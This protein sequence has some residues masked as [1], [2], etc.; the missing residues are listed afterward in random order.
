MSPA[1]SL[2]MQ[3]VTSPLASSIDAGSMAFAPSVAPV[4]L[5]AAAAAAAA[6]RRRRRSAATAAHQ[7]R[8]AEQ[9][10]DVVDYTHLYNP[11]PGRSDRP[12]VAL[13]YPSRCDSPS[14]RRRGRAPVDD[15]Q[16]QLRALDGARRPARAGAAAAPSAPLSSSGC[17]TVVRPD[18]TARP[19]R[20]RSRS[21]RARSGTGTPAACAASS[22]PIAC[23]SEVAKTAVGRVAARQQ[24]GRR[25]ARGV[26]AVA[27][28]SSDPARARAARRRRPAPPRSPRAGGRW[29]RS[30]SRFSSSSP[31]K[32]IRRWPSASRCS[33]ARRP[34]STSSIVIAG[35]VACARSSSTIG[36]LA[37]SSRRT[38]RVGR[39]ERD[40]RA[41]P[42]MRPRTASRAEE[43]APLLGPLDV[44]QDQLVAALRRARATRRAGARSTDGC[45]EEGRDHADRV[46]PAGR[47]RA[48]RRRS[49]GSRASRSPRAR[50]GACPRSPT[51]SR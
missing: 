40:R 35:S 29:S 20:C 13:L 12:R 18:V 2:P 46:R 39:G 45:G 38:S 32:A 10:R 3:T 25:V 49:A 19:P 11:P 36:T 23:T 15:P 17:A 1:V 37:T 48:R 33:A 31:T 16:R 8:A 30:R 6:A 43:V 5:G 41:A 50:A 14:S 7:R 42:S 27:A 47:E 26:A 28:G 21:P 9:R 24:L 44:E 22:T 4:S 34:P 51:A